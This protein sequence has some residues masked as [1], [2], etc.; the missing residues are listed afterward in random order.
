MN[1]EQLEY[2]V[3]VANEKSISKAAEKLH[4]SPSG[5]SQ[6]I[7]QLEKELEIN[8]FNRSRG[9]VTLTN[10]GEIVLTSSIEILNNLTHLKEKLA[11][12]KETSLKHIHLACAPTFTFLLY[13]VL[14]KYTGENRNVTFELIEKSTTQIMNNFT[15]DRFDLALVVS[16][17]AELEKENK[18]NFEYLCTGYVC[19]LVGKNSPFYNLDFVTANDLNNQKVVMYNFSN[20]NFL[21]MAKRFKND[22]V[23]KSNRT[24]ALIEMIKENQVFKYTHNTTLKNF[25]EV[26]KGE[27]KI[28]PI[29][30]N[31]DFIYQDFWFVSPS[32]RPISNTCKEFIQSIKNHLQSMTE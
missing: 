13:D 6:A 23:F 2:I 19:V 18:L 31:D 12:N 15:N 32:D 4:I 9:G 26:R 1:F 8:I 29:K 22:I 11:N 17:K 30:E 7:S 28:L 25:P 20:K 10:Q 27:L 3:T 16:T 24:L 21:Q 5:I 14:K